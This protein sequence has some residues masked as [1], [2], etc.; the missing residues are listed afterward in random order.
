[1]P[2][3]LEMVEL[4]SWPVNVPDDNEGPVFLI[5]TTESGGI[6]LESRRFTGTS[7]G[8]PIPSENRK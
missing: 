6:C 7:L 8:T 1:M 4:P 2:V 3:N 5:C